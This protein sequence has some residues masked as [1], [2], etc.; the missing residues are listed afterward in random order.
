MFEYTVHVHSYISVHHYE[1]EGP[2][3][4][5]YYFNCASPSNKGCTSMSISFRV[6]PRKRMKMLV[7]S[8]ESEATLP[9][10]PPR[11]KRKRLASKEVQTSLAAAAVADAPAPVVTAVVLGQPSKSPR[12]RVHHAAS[13]AA[14]SP[15]QL[16]RRNA[17]S[18]SQKRGRK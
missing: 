16:R 10:S 1:Y 2:S 13:A 5:C 14:I 8:S 15:M 6:R 4:T 3:Y 7:A 17:A 18:P 9:P 12:T 11:P